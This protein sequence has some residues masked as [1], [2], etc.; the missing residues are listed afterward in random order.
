MN[1]GVVLCY[2]S[3]FV[4]QEDDRFH[5]RGFRQDRLLVGA[6]AGCGRAKGHL[7]SESQPLKIEA[8]ATIRIATVRRV[9]HDPLTL[10]LATHDFNDRI[11]DACPTRLNDRAIN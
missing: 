6:P 9:L 4:Q 7:D 1:F 11:L 2:G 3:L 8:D 10:A 5:W